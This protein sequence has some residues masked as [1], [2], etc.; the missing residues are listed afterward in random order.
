MSRGMSTAVIAKKWGM[1]PEKVAAVSLQIHSML[2]DGAVSAYREYGRT[3]GFT[4]DGKGALLPE[5]R[6]SKSTFQEVEFEIPEPEASVVIDR[7]SQLPTWV[8]KIAQKIMEG[9]DAGDI[10]AACKISVQRMSG[11]MNQISCAVG[12]IPSGTT[13]KAARWKAAEQRL[14]ALNASDIEF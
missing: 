11:I 8:K 12:I 6:K 1:P 4:D 2:G 10:P 13:N 7:V 14:R 9:V 3:L 5:L